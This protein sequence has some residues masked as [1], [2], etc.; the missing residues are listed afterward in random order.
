M[1]AN[2]PCLYAFGYF[3]FSFR[4]YAPVRVSQRADMHDLPASARL[5]DECSAN[6]TRLAA[7]TRRRSGRIHLAEKNKLNTADARH[8][9]EIFRAKL[10]SLAIHDAEEPSQSEDR[11]AHSSSAAPGK[12]QKTKKKSVTKSVDKSG[13]AHPEP[14][15]VREHVRYVAK[16]PCLICGRQPTDAHHLR[17][18]QSRGLGRKVS[19]EF[20][21]PLCRG[22]HRE[23]HRQGDETGWWNARGIDLNSAA[24]AL[25]LRTHPALVQPGNG[26]G[27]NLTAGSGVLSLNP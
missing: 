14:R 10:L 3:R 25:W 7:A 21:V 17:F 12:E 1:S 15:R 26:N 6:S 20:T 8:I 19:D 16:Q 18:A 24:R 27:D 4:M 23:L 22:H 9:E 5:R 13:L 11:S 2:T